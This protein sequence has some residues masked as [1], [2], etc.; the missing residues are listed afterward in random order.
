M[1]PSGA[2]GTVGVVR[3]WDH[4]WGMCVGWDRGMEF[5]TCGDAWCVAIHGNRLGRWYG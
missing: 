4:L 2:R 3:R 5:Q 1:S